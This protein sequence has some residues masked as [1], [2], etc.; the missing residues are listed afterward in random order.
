MHAIGPLRLSRVRAALYVYALGAE[1]KGPEIVDDNAMV[2][3][4]EIPKGDLTLV[5]IHPNLEK[6]QTV[7]C[8]LDEYAQYPGS[9]CRNG[10]IIRVKDGHAFMKQLYPIM[11]ALLPGTKKSNCNLWRTCSA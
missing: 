5:K 2:V 6:L 8:L 4:A 1:G 10:A 7:E 9:D 11:A 3:D